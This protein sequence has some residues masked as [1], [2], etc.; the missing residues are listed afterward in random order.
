MVDIDTGDNRNVAIEHVDRVQP[1]TQADFQDHRIQI[2]L[3][4]QM[5]DGQRGEFKIGERNIAARCF[6]RLE[7]G[8][9]GRIG[10]AFAAQPRALVE[11]QEMRLDIQA[12]AITG[13]QQDRF[14]HRAGGTL[15]IGAADHDH[16]TFE[17][18]S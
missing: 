16:R 2:L 18:D 9:Q 17:A 3:R 12:D 14:Q 13:A 6:D 4:K 11:M 5:H 8:D 15:A 7:T 10:R 1:S